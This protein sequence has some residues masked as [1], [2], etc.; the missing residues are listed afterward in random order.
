[1]ERDKGEGRE[2]G[3]EEDHVTDHATCDSWGV[4]ASQRASGAR[5]CVATP[6]IPRIQSPGGRVETGCGSAAQST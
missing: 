4:A 2:G 6:L 1:M 3:P 5:G